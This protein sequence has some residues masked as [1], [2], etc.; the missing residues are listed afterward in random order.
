[1][2]S[3]EVDKELI[4]KGEEAIKDFNQKEQFRVVPKKLESKLICIRLPVVLVKELRAVA[5]AK[6]DIGY[7]QVIKSYIAEGLKIESRES[8]E[9]EQVIQ[10]VEILDQKISA[11]LAKMH[12]PL[13]PTRSLHGPCQ[14]LPGVYLKSALESTQTP[15]LSP[16]N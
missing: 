11:V 12:D 16:T 8:V 10:K 5:Q 3:D 7:Q 9:L 2:E 1:M 13:E 4:Q 14:E 6:G 15:Q